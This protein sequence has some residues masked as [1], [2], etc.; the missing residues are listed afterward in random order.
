LN[1]YNWHS[2]C[3]NYQMTWLIHYKKK[4]Q[5]QRQPPSYIA[6][7][8]QILC[9]SC[10]RLGAIHEK[11]KFTYF[12]NL[13]VKVCKIWCNDVYMSILQCDIFWWKLIDRNFLIRF[14]IPRWSSG[15]PPFFA[16]STVLHVIISKQDIPILGVFLTPD[17]NTSFGRF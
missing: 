5:K 11:H 6:K 14:L 4:H 13:M 9:S 16:V 2:G 1:S 15:H 17:G 7:F 8:L 12:K 10:I 3:P